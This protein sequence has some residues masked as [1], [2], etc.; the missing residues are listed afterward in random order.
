[1]E[2]DD[3]QANGVQWAEIDDTRFLKVLGNCSNEND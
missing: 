2:V 1:M 3:L